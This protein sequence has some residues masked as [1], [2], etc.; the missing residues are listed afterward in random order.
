[1]R[2]AILSEFDADGIN[3]I[4]ESLRLKGYE[5]PLIVT[6]PGLISEQNF[7]KLEPFKRRILDYDFTTPVLAMKNLKLLPPVL[8]GIE[9]DIILTM[10]FPFR[11]SQ[12]ILDIAKMRAVNFHPGKLPKYRGRNPI[13]WQILNKESTMGLTF[14]ITEP[15]YDTGS[16][17]LQGDIEITDDDDIRTLVRKMLP[18]AFIRLLPKVFEKVAQGDNG[19]EQDHQAAT[20]APSFTPVQRTVDW[21]KSTDEIRRLIRAAANHGVTAKTD[22]GEYKVCR[23]KQA[24]SQPSDLCKPGQEVQSDQDGSLLVQGTDGQMLFTEFVKID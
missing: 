17:L 15:E 1:M 2:I 5:I 6:T 7:Q 11:L 10:R 22:K 12:E 3:S 24:S 13:G 9:P 16:I 18:E 19:I 23:S 8:R 21:S 14:H 20:Y 4:V